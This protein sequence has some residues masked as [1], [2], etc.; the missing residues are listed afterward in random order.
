[1]F[2]NKVQKRIPEPKK[3]EATKARKLY[4]KLSLPPFFPSPFLVS[5]TLSFLSHF[6][7]FLLSV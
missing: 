4:K 2:E 5:L 7:I 3:E 1:M 6:F